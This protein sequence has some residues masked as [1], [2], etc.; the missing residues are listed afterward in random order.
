MF[1]SLKADSTENWGV[2]GGGG[3]AGAGLGEGREWGLRGRNKKW[4]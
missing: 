3:R 4:H 1:L 2:V